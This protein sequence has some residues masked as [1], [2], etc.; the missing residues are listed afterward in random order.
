MPGP[1]AL[2]ADIAEGDYVEIG[3]LGAYGTSL[4]TGF[5]GFGQ[6]DYVTVEDQPFASMFDTSTAA[7]AA[8]GA[9]IDEELA[10]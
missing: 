3:M 7:P 9:F 5:N 6:Y 8:S 10:R 4:A 2:P 1:Y